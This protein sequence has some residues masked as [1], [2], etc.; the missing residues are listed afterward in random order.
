MHFNTRLYFYQGLWIGRPGCLE[1]F[2][3]LVQEFYEDKDKREAVLKKA[4][5]ESENLTSEETKASASMYVKTMRKIIEKG[6]DF[7]SSEVKRVEKLRSGKV[8]DKKKEQLSDRLNVL[9]TFKMRSKDE[10]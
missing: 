5:V 3:K 1:N 8:S 2:D 4:E 7:I 10:L 9:S 6:N